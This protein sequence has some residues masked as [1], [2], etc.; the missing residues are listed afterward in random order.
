MN[1]AFLIPSTSNKRD[2]KDINESY[3][4]TILLP[5]L[6]KMKSHCKVKVFVG[7]D[8]DDEIYCKATRL[9]Q[10]DNIEIVWT[11]FD[12]S[13]KG[14]P[15]GIWNGLS[16]VAIK[17]GYDYL[18]V[19]GDDILLPDDNWLDYFILN[20]EL[21]DN[22]GFSA[23][24]SNNNQIP[25]QFLVH[26]KHV[27]IFGFIYPPAIKNYYCDNWM[28]DIYPDKYRN[29][30][31]EIKLLNCGGEPRYKPEHNRKLWDMLIKRN[32]KVLNKYLS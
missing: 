24:W 29:W 19:L 22:I 13:F 15:V 18:M 9:I 4:Y 14:N 28:Y 23:G 20:L 12:D 16:E 5:S 17:A 11:G 7:Y 30:N 8:I 26:K 10:Y 3:L 32:K 1:V 27:E 21:K 31:K 2:W 6:S 25:T